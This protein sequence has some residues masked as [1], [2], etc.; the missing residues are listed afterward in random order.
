M[1]QLLSGLYYM[2]VRYSSSFQYL[3]INLLLSLL[4]LKIPYH[5]FLRIIRLSGEPASKGI[6]PHAPV[7]SIIV[8][9]W[10]IHNASFTAIFDLLHSS[11]NW[12]LIKKHLCNQSSH[13]EKYQWCCAHQISFE[14]W[15]IYCASSSIQP[16]AQINNFLKKHL[17]YQ[18]SLYENMDT[19][20]QRKPSRATTK[21]TL[22]V[23]S[24]DGGGSVQFS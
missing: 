22:I 15:S 8:W 21:S 3:F 4:L 6:V 16:T 2:I 17:C 11:T 18:S 7:I 14:K 9:K 19:I 10:C 12:E 24:K 20:V 13:Y 23:V 1:F 5:F